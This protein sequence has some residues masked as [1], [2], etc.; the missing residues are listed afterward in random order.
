ML[1]LYRRNA[2]CYI[3]AQDL[4]TDMK[5]TLLWISLLWSLVEVHSQTLPYVSFMNE[6]LPNHS[7][8]DLTLVGDPQL[9]DDDHAI[10]CHTD[11]ST[12]CSGSQGDHRGDWYFPDG[13]RLPFAHPTVGIHEAR[14]AQ[15]VDLRRNN[16]ANSP[17]GV[18][19]CDI[20][21]DAVQDNSVRETVY[22]GLYATGG[23]AILKCG[24]Q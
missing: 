4:A 16:N 7:Y 5:R 22:V 2:L 11:L 8:V 10:Q 14:G 13:S 19:R 6:S 18:Y 21:T 17:S 3:P 24:D 9:N 23:I 20:T 12:C 1:L 15:R